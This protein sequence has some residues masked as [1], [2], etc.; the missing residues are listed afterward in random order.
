MNK[1]PACSASGLSTQ[2]ERQTRKIGAFTFR[3]D[4]P[5]LVCRKCGESYVAGPDLQ[6]FE[7][8]AARELAHL[9]VRSGEALKFMRKAAGLKAAELAEL[10]GVSAETISRWETDKVPIDWAAFVAVGS[11][12]ADKIEGRTDTLERLRALRLP[13]KKGGSI[14]VKIAS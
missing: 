13:P 9:G 12:V 1:C 6:R 4:L 5:A 8:A 2:S 3:A 10:L 14:D 7:L 11:L